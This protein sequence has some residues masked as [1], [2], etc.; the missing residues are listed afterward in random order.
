MEDSSPWDG[1]RGGRPSFR[2]REKRARE[3][4]NTKMFAKF[5]KK[6]GPR[7]I[8]RPSGIK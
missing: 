4:V 2:D 6:R 5:S 3:R 8:K 1:M 7:T